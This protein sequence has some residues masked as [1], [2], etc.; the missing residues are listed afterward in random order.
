MILHFNPFPNDKFKGDPSGHG[1]KFYKNIENASLCSQSLLIF[2]HK[3]PVVENHPTTREIGDLLRSRST[4]AGN[5][6]Y[7]YMSISLIY[8]LKI[9]R[10][11]FKHSIRSRNY[12][13]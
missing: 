3:I 12:G 1:R 4:L 11:S 2:I 8:I 9:H 10:W 5:T 13:K 6:F 7:F